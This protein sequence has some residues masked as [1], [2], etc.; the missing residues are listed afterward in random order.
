MAIRVSCPTCSKSLSAPDH[1]AG[2]N[3]R[4]PGCSTSI[5]LPDA[6][7]PATQAPPVL[8]RHLPPQEDYGAPRPRRRRSAGIPALVWVGV[9]VAGVLLMLGGVSVA[10]WQLGLLGGNAGG[11]SANELRYAPDDS[12]VFVTL[13]GDAWANSKLAER[14]A[15]LL[16]AKGDAAKQARTKYEEERI[17]TNEA[18]TKEIVPGT[19]LHGNDFRRLFLA[20]SPG[21]EEAVAVVAL[22]KP[23]TTDAL[24]ALSPLGVKQSTVGKYTVLEAQMPG[25]SGAMCLVE[26]TT[27]VFANKVDALKAVLE[28]GRAAKLSAE[29]LRLLTGV[30][31]TKLFTL[32]VNAA[33]L[34]AK[35]A[36]PGAANPV[37][38]MKLVPAEWQAVTRATGLTVEID[39]K[40]AVNASVALQCKD[41]DDAG[42]LRKLID[43]GLTVVRERAKQMQEQAPSSEQKATVQRGLQVLDGLQLTADGAT[44][45]GKWSVSAEQVAD[46]IETAPEPSKLL[47]PG[48]PLMTPTAPPIG[49]PPKRR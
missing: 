34:K 9:A 1:F 15:S 13:D 36:A 32:V 3:C 42:S 27:V 20:Y 29:S 37:D 35:P 28:R 45:R 10:A 40:T 49:M 4:C 48:L 22:R 23:T 38:L 26:P 2:R 30:D 6:A 7:P 46:L 19:D 39:N 8:D 18:M 21:K 47:G 16:Q 11:L 24:G 12:D 44:I 43:G 25:S 31:A 14:V 41:A 17:R 5:R 33:N